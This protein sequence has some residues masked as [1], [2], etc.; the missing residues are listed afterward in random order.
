[1]ISRA[2]VRRMRDVQTPVIPV[3][4]TWIAETPGTISLGQGIV[5]WGPPREAI[6][7]LRAFP[8]DASDNVY[9]PVEGLPELLAVIERK[10]EAENR[11]GS[12]GNRV[13]VT[14]GG[15]QA[16]MNALLAITDPGDEVILQRPYYFNHGMAIVMAGCTPVA[17]PTD[18]SYQLQPDAVAAAITPR[19]RAIVTVSPN[20]PTGAVYREADL[21][22]VNAICRD[23]GLYH[24][25]DEVYEYFLYG[26]ARH[27]SP[28]SIEGAEAWTISLF[29]LSKAYGMA[30]WRVGYMAAPE[31]L[32]GS[33]LKIQDTIVISATNPTQLAAAAAM[34]VGRASLTRHLAR[35]ARV[36]DRARD[37]LGDVADV[38]HADGAFYYL[39]RAR[40]SLDSMAA[41]ERLIR[42]HR[43]A[44]VPGAAFGVTEGCALRISFGALEEDTAHEGLE[45][46]AAGLRA[47]R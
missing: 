25:S 34:H 2:P 36:R 42:N 15:N 39:I 31:A 26:G 37:V 28:G 35:L 3:V 5:S 38:P 33:L 27:F 21:R 44:V 45:R 46:L 40:T 7:A 16:F 47:L 18:G 10:L 9:G 11:I 43:V 14:A 22:A 1:M 8:S 13:M 20:N 24:I 6:D 19:T 4:S 29:S 32:W 30:G 41:A 23:R 17:V 12:T